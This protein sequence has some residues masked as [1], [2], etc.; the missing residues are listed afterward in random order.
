MNIDIIFLGFILLPVIGIAKTVNT[1]KSSRKVFT[2]I[3]ELSCAANR[4]KAFN[5]MDIGY[6]YSFRV[7]LNP[8]SW[9]AKHHYP[10]VVEY[11]ESMGIEVK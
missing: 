1:S 8:F 2:A 9:S 4:F 5:L 11:L 10:A 3:D 7:V 6:A